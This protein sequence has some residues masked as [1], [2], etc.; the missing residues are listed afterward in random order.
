MNKT[1]LL[2]CNT[3]KQILDIASVSGQKYDT[4][5]KNM[6]L[7]S[8]TPVLR[9]QATSLTSCATPSQLFNLCKV[10]FPLL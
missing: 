2:I 3:K 5:A 6:V 7:E 10:K 4:V 9:L 8:D 1:K